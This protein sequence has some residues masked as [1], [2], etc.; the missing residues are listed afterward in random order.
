M[1]HIFIYI[2]LFT[3]FSLAI[4]QDRGRDMRQRLDRELAI[5]NFLVQEHPDAEAEIWLQDAQ[6]LRDEL[7]EWIRQRNPAKTRETGQSAHRLALRII[8]KLSPL[9]YNER[10]Q[11]ISDLINQAQTVVPNS[12][13]DEAQRL[14]GEA[15]KNLQLAQQHFED[16]RLR[17][18]FEAFRTAETQAKRSLQLTHYPAESVDNKL[19]LEQQRFSRLLNRV[20]IILSNCS[21]TNA[22]GLYD[23]ALNRQV[24]IN[25]L[26]LNEEKEAALQIYYQST[27]LLLRALNLCDGSAASP[28]QRAEQQVQLLEELVDSVQRSDLRRV[29]VRQ[30]IRLRRVTRLVDQAKLALANNNFAESLKLSTQARNLL[31]RLLNEEPDDR[32]HRVAQEI[33][34]LQQSINKAKEGET[35]PRRRSFIQ[36]AEWSLQDAKTFLDQGDLDPAVQ[37]ILTGNQFLSA[38]ENANEPVTREITELKVSEL[39]LKI[40]VVKQREG[41]EYMIRAAETIQQRIQA[42]MAEGNFEIA[43]KYASLAIDLLQLDDF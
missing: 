18:A 28:A 12:G 10:F 26:L 40:A 3:T 7:D 4:A 42:S 41:D 34:R 1:K 19:E 11:T 21:N 14:L 16:N 13:N 33:Q 17:P 31:S 9:H 25:R 37:S 30:R 6:A 29:P 5:A 43:Y 38:L 27:R 20:E 24:E 2:F 32:T 23:Q 15:K 35:T 22:R 8:N 36:A 39:S